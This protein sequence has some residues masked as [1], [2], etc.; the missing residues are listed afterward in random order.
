MND[1]LNF[2]AAVTPPNATGTVEFFTNGVS[3]DMQTLVA[4]QATSTDLV[5]LPGGTNV[6]TAVYSG[7]QNDLATTNSLVQIVTNHPPSLV[8]IPD[9]TITAGMTLTL[10]NTATDPDGDVL[11]FSFGPGCP[12]NANLDAVTGIFNWTPVQAQ[13]GTNAFTVIASDNGLPSLSASQSFAVT[14]V[15]SNNPPVLAPIANQTIYALTTL[16][17]TNSATDPDAPPQILS[18]TL[19]P[20]APSGSSIG[21][22]SGIFQWTPADSETGPHSI[23]VR[24]ADNGSPVLNDA[25]TFTVTVLSHP[26]QT[27]S[28]SNDVVML[29]WSSVSGTVYRV[30]FKS[31]LS[32]AA[33][34]DLSPDVQASGPIASVTNS[35]ATNASTFYR[36]QV[37]P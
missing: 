14:V 15:P 31:E 20:G 10:T 1:S 32:D 26:L 28:V 19:D 7:D 17:L 11:T 25:H 22:T 29:S 35:M 33:W 24:V 21:L 16:T 27:I 13:A 37:Q 18:Y 36:L 34:T 8:A 6:I 30:Q 2:T 4:G 5:S 3:F 23:T 9:Q 12:T